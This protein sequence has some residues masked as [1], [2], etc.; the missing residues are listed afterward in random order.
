ME[1]I[2]DR[3]G[4]EKRRTALQPS[5]HGTGGEKQR[6]APDCF[7]AASRPVVMVHVFAGRPSY[8]AHGF[9]LNRDLRSCVV[10]C[11]AGLITFSLILSNGPLPLFSDVALAH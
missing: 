3:R 5:A 2:I 6:L 11:S 1:H 9:F 10:V 4:E 8:F 7:S